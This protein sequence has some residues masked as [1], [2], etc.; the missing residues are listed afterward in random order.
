MNEVITQLKKRFAELAERSYQKNVYVF[1]DFLNLSEQAVFFEQEREVS[2]AGY[3][4]WGGAESSERR[5]LRFGT[6]ELLGYE[7]P[8]PITCIRIRPAAKKFAEDL[9]HRDF[10][11][12]LMHLG[13]ERSVLGDICLREQEAYLICKEEMADYI[14]NHLDKVRHTVVKCEQM[15]EM[16]TEIQPELKEEELIVSSLRADAIV[17]KV[18]QLSR[19][20]SLGLFRGK[21]VFVNGRQFENNSG[22]WQEGDIVSVRGYGRFRYDGMLQETKKG[23]I[24]FLI[25]KYI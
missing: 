7:E 24:R 14:V 12:A 11:G 15:N 2:Y 22:I 19:N 9:N 23:R 18:W 6:E 5:M 3:T 13:I 21:K 1:T 4:L 20:Q 10:L 25:Q 8:F 17:A 16:P